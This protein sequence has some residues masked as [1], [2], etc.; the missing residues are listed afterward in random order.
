MNEVQNKKILEKLGD[1]VFLTDKE[2]EDANFFE[3]AL[4]LQNLNILE[5]GVKVITEQAVDKND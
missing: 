4:Y 5:E 3:L 2:I 1:I